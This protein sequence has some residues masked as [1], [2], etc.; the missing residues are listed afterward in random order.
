MIFTE[1][2]M[3][4]RFLPGTGIAKGEEGKFGKNLSNGLENVTGAIEVNF[5]DIGP[6]FDQVQDRFSHFASEIVWA[7]SGLCCRVLRE[8]D[9]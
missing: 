6:Y 8:S 9:L 1:W 5:R 7:P 3:Q 2:E 4:R